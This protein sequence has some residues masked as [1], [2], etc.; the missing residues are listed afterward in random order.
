MKTLVE[1][2]TALE[3][4]QSQIASLKSAFE[5]DMKSMQDT[6]SELLFAQKLLLNDLD[7]EKVSIA[8]SILRVEG[9]VTRNCEGEVIAELAAADIAKGC[10]HL[11]TRY[12]GNKRYDGFYQRND[13]EYGYGPK[14][15]SIVE[16]VGLK[17][18]SKILNPDEQ[19]ACI[20]M[21]LN[22][23]KIIQAVKTEK[24]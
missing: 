18:T 15:G 9:D 6:R 7:L 3:V 20:Y 1:I 12:F 22:Y 13:S 2:T 24:A 17:D 16:R 14:H 8:D 10:K 23:K 19:E 5:S 4:N 11:K 21:L